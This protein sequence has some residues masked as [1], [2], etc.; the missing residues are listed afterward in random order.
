MTSLRKTALVAG[1][2]YLLTFVGS[3]VGS[4]LLQP[5]LSEPNFM[6]TPGV[7]GQIGAAAAFEL[8]NVLALI[9]TAVAVFSLVKREHEGLA[10]G[11]VM[12]RMFEA[13][14]IV[15]GIVS[16][17]SLVTLRQAAAA[18]TD[19]ASLMPVGQALV[20]VREWSLVIGPSMAAFNALMFG[21]LLFRSRLVPRAIPALGLI[22]APLLISWVIGTRLGVTSPGT[23]WHAIA[24]APFFFWELFV[25][26][27]MT[28]KGFNTSAPVAIAFAAESASRDASAT[29]GLSRSAVAS[30]AGA[31]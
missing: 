5:I 17:L 2:L 9:G 12:T 11:F 8:V 24:V 28:F 3:I 14:V 25:G 13:A 23:E 31:A 4:L 20:A 18:G 6:V 22:G 16:I 30:Q 19:A 29:A 27:W 10:L 15:I 26:L 21:T 1:V 7:D